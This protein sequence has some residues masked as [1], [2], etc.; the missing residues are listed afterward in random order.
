MNYMELAIIEAKKS[1]IDIPVG[2]VIVKDGKV[3]AKAHN[4]REKNNDV[5]SHAEIIAMREAEKL[6]NN[7]RLTDC[8]MYVT[9]EPCPMCGWAI[10]QSRIKNLYFGAYDNVYGAFST[11]L[12][13]KSVANSKLE[14]YGGIMEEECQKILT[15]YFEK[16]RK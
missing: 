5:T 13:L 4:L 16:M 14:V 10:L 6:L 9:L 7:W 11:N 15:Q 3:I 8:E 2:A 12:D 1:D